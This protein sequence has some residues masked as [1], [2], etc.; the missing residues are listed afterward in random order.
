MN[1]RQEFTVDDK[2][3]YVTEPSTKDLQDADLLYTKEFHK[4]LK[5]GAML[6]VKLD[7][8]L[9]EQGLWSD[10]Q[11]EQYQSL[12]KRV[13][14]GEYKLQKGG[15]PLSQAKEVAIDMTRARR[16]MLDLLRPRS[17]LEDVTVEGIAENRRLQ[18]LTVRNTYDANTH[19][20]CFKTLD[21][22][23]NTENRKL[24][25]AAVREF[26][27]LLYSGILRSD[28][29]LPENQFLKRWKFVD[30]KLR[31]I[32]RD[33]HLVNVRGERVDEK[34]RRINEGGEPVDEDGRV[35]TDDGVYK[36][37]GEPFLDD[38]GNPI[39]ETDEAADK[40]ESVIDEIA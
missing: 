24:G 5:E 11:E 17:E 39:V 3:Y 38:D 34:G 35:L 4:A 27:N 7:E 18:F 20:L 14:D 32:D 13:D 8:Y 6:R 30:D 16:E 22:L 1:K 33:G 31:Y 25:I 19:T 10:K 37:E 26:T 15:I 40:S 12:Q 36:V 2:P 21:D 29:E 9:R 28:S 23:L